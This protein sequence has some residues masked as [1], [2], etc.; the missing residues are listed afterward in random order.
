VHTFWEWF[1]LVFVSLAF[2][3]YRFAMSTIALDSGAVTQ[4]EFEA[5]EV[6]ALS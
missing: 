2:V 1:C 5:L 4:E 6:R 3:A